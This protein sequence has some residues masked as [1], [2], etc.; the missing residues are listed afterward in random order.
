MNT[1]GG[2]NVPRVLIRQRYGLDA[3]GNVGTGNNQPLHARFSSAA[4][5][6]ITVCVKAVVGQIDTNI[7]EPVH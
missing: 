1:G 5:D 6:V 2:K 4:D 3:A 7:D